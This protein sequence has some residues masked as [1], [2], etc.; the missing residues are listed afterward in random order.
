MTESE[1]ELMKVKEENEWKCC[2]KTSILK[3][4]IMAS[5]SS[6]SWQIEI[7]WKQWQTLFSWS[8]NSLW[9]LTAAMKI[10]TLAP[11]EKSND[12]P[13]QHMKKQRHSFSNKGPSSQSYVFSSSHV[14]MWGLDHRESWTLKNWCFW[15][16][17]LENTLESALDYKEIKP[18]NPKGNQ[19]WIFIGRTDAEAPVLWSS[20]VKSQ[21]IRKDPHA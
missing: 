20:V 10:K 17:V 3:T 6:M 9:M 13:R 4:K 12:K 16:V 15:T 11:W 5:G 1:E 19:S 14:W 18:V 2:L 21:F 7:Q 8:P